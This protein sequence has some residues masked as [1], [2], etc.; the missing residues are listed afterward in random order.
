MLTWG[1][2]AEVQKQGCCRPR[3][4]SRLLTQADM[5][6]WRHAASAALHAA[7]VPPWSHSTSCCAAWTVHTC[8]RVC[9]VG[10]CV[11]LVQGLGFTTCCSICQHPGRAWVTG[12]CLHELGPVYGPAAGQEALGASALCGLRPAPLFLALLRVV[13]VAEKLCIARHVAA[14]GWSYVAPGLPVR[15]HYIS[16]SLVPPSATV[17]ACDL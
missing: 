8:G 9:V 3:C 2:C 14:C 11:A 17:P 1:S 5:Q 16:F 15:S 13:A 10:C 7:V 6:R 4:W 12:P